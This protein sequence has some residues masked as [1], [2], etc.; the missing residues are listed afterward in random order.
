MTAGAKDTPGFKIQNDASVVNEHQRCLKLHMPRNHPRVNQTSLDLIQ[1]WRGNCDI[2][3]M[4]SEKL[5]K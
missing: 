1:T 2:Q 3:I 5:A 4:I